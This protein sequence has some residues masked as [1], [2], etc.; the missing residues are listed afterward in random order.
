ML[1]CEAARRSLYEDRRAAGAPRCCSQR[2]RSQPAAAR[3]RTTLC[4]LES[5]PTPRP[6]G[7]PPS[8]AIN[9]LSSSSGSYPFP[10]PP[11]LVPC[12]P[13][14]PVVQ[15]S[16]SEPS[17]SL[18]LRSGSATAPARS[19]VCLWKARGKEEM[20]LSACSRRLSGSVRSR[21]LSVSAAGGH[22]VGLRSSSTLSTLHNLDEDAA[23][24]CISGK[25]NGFDALGFHLTAN[26]TLDRCSKGLGFATLGRPRPARQTQNGTSRTLPRIS[27]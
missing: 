4:S 13:L 25:E 20:A 5:A 3:G 27:P 16:A 22:P 18:C 9:L 21:A 24:A 15:P 10:V 26:P 14:T 11:A 7:H 1:S 19:S 17:S 2:S 23:G 8:P 6:H 12:P